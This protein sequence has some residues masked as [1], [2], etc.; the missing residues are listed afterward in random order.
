[1]SL[2]RFF[3]ALP[4]LACSVV[5]SGLMA[6]A[7]AQQP[8]S[9]DLKPVKLITVEAA[10]SAGERRFLG[11]IAARETVDLA[12][13]IGGQLVEFPAIE[14][15]FVAADAV[16]AQ[17]NRAPLERSL[18]QA[19]LSLEQAERNLQRN[20]QLQQR[21][22]S[23]TEAQLEDARTARDQA[24]VGLEDARAALNDATL[25]S[26]FD[27]LVAERMVAN[28]ATV[29][30][31]QP[32]LRLHDMSE[33]RVRISMP[34][35]LL[36]V[37][38]DPSALTYQLQLRDGGPRYDLAF[39]E[40]VA[41]AGRIGQSYAV[42]LALE[43]TPDR[44][45]LP[46]ASSTVIVRLP[47]SEDTGIMV[48]ATA[49]VADASRQTHVF[50]FEPTGADEGRVRR[51]P[52]TVDTPDG[53]TLM[54]TSGLRPGMEIVATGAHRLADGESVRRFSGYRGAQ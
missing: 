47:V 51:V 13:Q 44:T 12:F 22:A 49:A 30:A 43:E 28:R 16:L 41:E 4:A 17:L 25:T 11:R 31:G 6:N 54:V 35:R 29:A 52:V 40:F 18:R 27:G 8:P 20:L 1:M 38:G 14:G 21:N 3:Q 32:V 5:L 10:T 23:T 53:T 24:E 19:E 33:L 50:V 42:T 37:I 7:F 39:R 9:A 48:P 15:R 36:G 2:F 34:E 45:L 26:P 46:G